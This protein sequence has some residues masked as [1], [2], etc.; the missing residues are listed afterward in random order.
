M[1][2]GLL[3]N[4]FKSAII[5]GERNNESLSL[6]RQ[7]SVVG[8][9]MAG[10]KKSGSDNKTPQLRAESEKDCRRRNGQERMPDVLRTYAK[11]R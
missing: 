7:Q 11:F 9:G 3:R 10:R 4:L 8:R 2:E 1:T 6:G 5:E